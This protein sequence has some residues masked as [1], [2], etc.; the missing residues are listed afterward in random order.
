MQTLSILKFLGL[1]LLVERQLF[2][3]LKF[4][5]DLVEAVLVFWVVVIEVLH[6]V[7]GLVKISKAN[8]L[9]DYFISKAFSRLFNRLGG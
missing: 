1:S 3:E 7:F 4:V 2:D 5:G 6:E 9:R 8:Y